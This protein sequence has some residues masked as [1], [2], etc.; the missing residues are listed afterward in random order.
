MESRES[1]QRASRGPLM[2]IA[3]LIIAAAIIVGALIV[4]NAMNDANRTERCN[5]LKDS[6]NDGSP[7]LVFDME[8]G[9]ELGCD[10]AK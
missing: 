8:E 3:S 4:V 7:S 5:D 10:W 6:I 2:L 1:T 9:E